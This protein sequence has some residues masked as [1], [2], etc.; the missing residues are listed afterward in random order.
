MA[1]ESLNVLES[2][3]AELWAH[4]GKPLLP[5]V[6]VDDGILSVNHPSQV[7]SLLDLEI[8]D[9]PPNPRLAYDTVSI[10]SDWVDLLGPLDWKLMTS[11]TRSRG[12]SIRNLTVNTFHPFELIPVAWTDGSFDWQ[13]REDHLREAELTEPAHVVGYARDRLLTWQSFLLDVGDELEGDD[14]PVVS[15]RGD[16]TFSVLLTSQRW[17]CA[18][19]HRQIVDFLRG[20]GVAVPDAL[21]VEMLR[22]VGL[23]EEI[24]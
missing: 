7:A 17:H 22:D 4:H 15:P 8:D 13:P 9:L 10:L 16:I 18:F 6:E 20:E 12:R 23:S 11:P 21:D 14:R 19:H 5:T 2:P 24:Y 1:Y 3:G